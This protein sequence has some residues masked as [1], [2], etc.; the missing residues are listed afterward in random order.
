[1]VLKN[2][3][4]KSRQF[5]IFFLFFFF[6]YNHP[7]QWIVFLL[8]FPLS[9]TAVRYES[10]YSQIKLG[11]KIKLYY[12]ICLLHNNF[13]FS[14]L[15]FHTMAV[16]NNSW[17]CTYFYDRS[18]KSLEINCFIVISPHK[19]S[20]TMNSYISLINYLVIRYQSWLVF[21]YFANNNL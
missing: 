6:V 17:N 14:P 5:F 21:D 9:I 8:L 10:C 13:Y 16:N 3:L 1:M 20:F 12:V 19:R 2:I 11:M 15:R 4:H 7:T 18:F